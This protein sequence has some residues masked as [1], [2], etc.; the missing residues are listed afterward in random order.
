MLNLQHVVTYREI[1]SDVVRDP[2]AMPEEY[3]GD[4]SKMP[5]SIGE[6]LGDIM[7]VLWDMP[8]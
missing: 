1:C 3:V 2:L 8:K 6:H 7:V 4:Q 5:K